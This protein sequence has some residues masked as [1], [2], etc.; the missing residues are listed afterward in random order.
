[1]R[2]LHHTRPDLTVLFCLCYA[3][4]GRHAD[5]VRPDAAVAV[6]QQ[7]CRAGADWLAL[8]AGILCQWS[9]GCKFVFSTN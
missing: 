7:Q 5:N 9:F 8:A 6:G 1:M 4:A 2:H 3:A